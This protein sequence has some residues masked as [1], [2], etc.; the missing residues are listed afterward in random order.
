[1]ER[2]KVRKGTSFQK[3]F[4][5]SHA[6]RSSSSSKSYSR[7]QTARMVQCHPG[8]LDR[9]R[10]PVLLAGWS[11]RHTLPTT[12]TNTRLPEGKQ[13]LSENPIVCTNR[14]TEPLSPGRMV[15]TLLRAKFPAPG[16]WAGLLKDNSL[17]SAL[18]PLWH[19]AHQEAHSGGWGHCRTSR[20]RTEKSAH[21]HSFQ[22]TSSSWDVRASHKISLPHFTWP[23]FSPLT[24]PLHS[25]GQL[26]WLG[27]FCGLP[28]LWEW[29][30]KTS[31]HSSSREGRIQ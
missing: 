21:I 30:W 3:P 9:L 25:Q 1:M 5:G 20:K 10:A 22:V 13:L 7:Q 23:R 27:G 24:L 28:G 11:C 6:G 2:H 19:Y 26:H 29:V 18:Y 15:G 4:L 17:G 14:C 31:G 8:K 16:F 12:A